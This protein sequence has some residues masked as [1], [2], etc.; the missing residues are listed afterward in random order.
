MIDE[1]TDVNEGE[2][3]LMKIWNNHIMRSWYIFPY[4]IV[5][6]IISLFV[7]Y[8]VIVLF[9]ISFKLLPDATCSFQCVYV[10]IRA[11]IPVLASPEQWLV[12]LLVPCFRRCSRLLW[13]FP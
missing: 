5:S 9:F 10:L 7:S 11:Q 12:C 6:F 1:F 3:E 13:E 4:F 2:K 8:C